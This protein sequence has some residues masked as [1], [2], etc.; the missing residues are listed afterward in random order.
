MFSLVNILIK[1]ITIRSSSVD[2]V[3]INNEKVHYD[4]NVPLLF[5]F[6]LRHMEKYR[7]SRSHCPLQ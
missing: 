1:V 6:S 2:L 3:V 7:L 4:W 5:E